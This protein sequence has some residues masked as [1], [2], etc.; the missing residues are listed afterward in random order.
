MRGDPPYGRLSAANGGFVLPVTFHNCTESEPVH[1]GGPS[2][3]NKSNQK[4]VIATS[5]I[6]D[7]E[8]FHDLMNGTQ[9]LAFIEDRFRALGATHFL[10][11]GV[12]LPKKD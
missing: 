12:P 6:A 1:S 9:V 3:G 11:A 8:R 7:G 4:M 5:L 2:R 10:A